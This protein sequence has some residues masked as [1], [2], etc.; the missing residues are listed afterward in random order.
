[1]ISTN[2]PVEFY[3]AD[4]DT[5]LLGVLLLQV[6]NEVCMQWELHQKS[7]DTTSLIVQEPCEMAWLTALLQCHQCRLSK[8]LADNNY[9]CHKCTDY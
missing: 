8:W 3:C 7:G 1:M 4:D 2:V 9:V 5:I 6:K